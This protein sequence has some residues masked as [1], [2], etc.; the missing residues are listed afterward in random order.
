MWRR[1]S[2]SDFVDGISKQAI[3]QR[4]GMNN[5]HQCH[6]SVFF[7]FFK[8]GHMEVSGVP[9][10]SSTTWFGLVLLIQTDKH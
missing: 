5:V 1:A 3:P 9:D 4:R 2:I 10:T 8:C 6:M 7:F